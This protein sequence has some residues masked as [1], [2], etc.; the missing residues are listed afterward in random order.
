MVQIK[1]ETIE[2]HI[3]DIRVGD[4]IIENGHL[5]TIGRNNIK[6]G[7]FFGLTVRGDSYNLGARPVL[8]AVIKRAM[9]NCE[10]VNA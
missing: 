3:S 2:V 9:P 1:Y 7:Q 5:V 8:K 4:T 6:R 10:F